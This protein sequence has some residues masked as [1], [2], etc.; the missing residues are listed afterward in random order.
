MLLQHAKQLPLPA[1]QHCPVG[2]CES[3]VHG[4]LDEH[5]WVAV[6]QHSLARQS[7]LDLQH[8]THALPWQ[9]LPA[10]HW[11]SVQHA[12]AEMHEPLQH[13]PEPHCASVVHAQVPHCSVEGLQHW[14]ATQSA[15]DLQ[16]ALHAPLWQHWPE[17]QSPSE[18]HWS[19]E[20]CP[21]QHLPPAPH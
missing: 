14:P 17:P 6:S 5:F 18:Q 12:L 10:P 11:P 4:Q 13:C 15:F 7:E 2:H 21:L 8:G 16:H 1:L 19:L 20:H 9:H 3:V